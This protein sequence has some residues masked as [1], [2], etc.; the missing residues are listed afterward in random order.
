M[1]SK[2]RYIL[3]G[4]RAC[5]GSAVRK[6]IAKLIAEA[7]KQKFVGAANLKADNS[8]ASLA[9]NFLQLKALGLF[10]KNDRLLVYREREHLRQPNSRYRLGCQMVKPCV[11][12]KSKGSY[13]PKG[14]YAFEYQ[15]W[16]PPDLN[17]AVPLLREAGCK[18]QENLPGGV[19]RIIH[20]P[21]LLGT[22]HTV[23]ILNGI[24]LRPGKTASNPFSAK[25]AKYAQL[26]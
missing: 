2:V 17:W 6:T 20:V 16:E 4:S 9:H 1:P 24:V 19:F 26:G 3:L 15:V 5:Y 7:E 14:E 12:I 13:A 21:W 8:I 23:R 10:E 25:Q 11:G 22:G 18:V